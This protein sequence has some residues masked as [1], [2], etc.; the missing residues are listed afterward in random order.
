VLATAED[1]KE[2]GNQVP[3]ISVPWVD[4]QASLHHE[5]G[6]HRTLLIL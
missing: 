3:P 5:L 1:I 6:Q 4:N 2:E